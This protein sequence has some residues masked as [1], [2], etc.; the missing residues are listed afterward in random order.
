M[1]FPAAR[2]RRSA[3]ASH[4]A[5][6]A[7]RT[8]PLWVHPRFRRLS[9][10]VIVVGMHRS[11]TSLVAG[12]L[13]R[14]GVYM[15]P[16]LQLPGGGGDTDDQELLRAGYGEAEEF[17]Y[18]NDGLLRAAGASWDSIQ[19]FVARSADP[20]FIRSCAARLQRAT[21]G[22]LYWDYLSSMPRGY[23]GSWGWKDPRNTVTLPCWLA[24]F[25]DA[26]VVYVRRNWTPVAA[27]L[28]RRAL[29]PPPPPGAPLPARERVRWWLRHP[30]E[31]GL[32]L[33]RRVGLAQHPAP[34]EDP[35]RDR[36]FCEGLCRDYGDVAAQHLDLAHDPVVLWYEELLADP[37]ESVGRLA[38]RLE[39]HASEPL[40][41]S[42]AALV[43]RK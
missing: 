13:A 10:P 19:P 36:A 2:F 12:L 41:R 37:L 5:T 27:S 32:R 24:L 16:K 21:A 29:A 18:L 30:G 1:H 23:A 33:A 34:I 38:E 8:R 20:R 6:I 25:P 43:G 17:V 4:P 40:L 42:A 7:D 15:G 3:V 31:A 35:C 11:G 22:S 14:L 9:P 28:N 26:R 39:I